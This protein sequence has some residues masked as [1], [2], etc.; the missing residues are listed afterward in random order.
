MA[1]DGEVV[2]TA[3]MHENLE[4]TWIRKPDPGEVERAVIG[5]MLPPF[6]DDFSPSPQRPYLRTAR[7]ALRTSLAAR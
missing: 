2:L 6:N 3:W 7:K 1:G 5:V 4:A